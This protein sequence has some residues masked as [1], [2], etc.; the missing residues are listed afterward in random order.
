ME[1]FW[2]NLS[3]EF[4]TPFTNSVLIFSVI[5]FIILLVPLVFNRFKIPGIIGLILSG[6]LIGPH[7]LFLI[8]KN[9]AVNL[10][11]TIGL[12]YI[13]FIAGLELDLNDF[14]KNKNK[15]IVFGIFTFIIPIAIGLPVCLYVLQ[16]G[17]MTSLLISSM[18]A[19]HTLIA[20]PIV[21]RLGI[22]RNKAVA[23]AV[24]GTILTDTAVLIVLAVISGA[25]QGGVTYLLWTRLA[26]SILIFIAIVFVLIP[27]ISA[28]FFTRLEDEK[29]AHFI[30]VLSVVFFCAFL[31]EIAGLEPIIG[32]FAAG[33]TLNRLIPHHS[34]LMNRI[35]FVGNSLFIPFFLISV[36]M[37][38]DL[39][40]VTQGPQAIIIALTLTAVALLSKWIAAFFTGKVFGFSK[41]QTT[42]IFG[43]S[44]AHA[45]A[46]L[47]VILVGFNLKIIDSN[48]LNGTVVLILI[49]CVVASFTA[50]KAGKKVLLEMDTQPETPGY[51]QR[52]LVPISNPDTMG[53]LIDFA[54]MIKNQKDP[55]PIVGLSVVKDGEQA[56][57]K[58]VD[59]RKLLDKAIAHA[60]AADQK[61]EITCTIDRNVTSGIQR[62]VKEQSITEIVLGWSPDKTIADIIFGKTFD[63]LVRQTSQNIFITRFVGPLNVHQ[64][65][66]LVCP[67]FAEKEK[68]FFST[69]E[70]ALRAAASLRMGLKLYSTQPAHDAV[71][72]II[73]LVNATV[74]LEYKGSLDLAKIGML[75]PAVGEFDL[76]MIL[77][78]RAG[79]ISYSPLLDVIPKKMSKHF[80]GR[81]F[82]FVYP[83][84]TTS[85][86]IENY[87]QEV[88]GGLL[89]KG[90]SLVKNIFSTQK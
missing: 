87:E 40:V 50:E 38:I 57:Q 47:A 5:L 63:S 21:T 52:I 17:F 27:K 79:G 61:I 24:G 64:N 31:A 29:S 25:V 81:S 83:A 46:T 20:Y 35:E 7:G 36:G 22:A 90:I 88:T 14:Q 6:I 69:I 85:N 42:L 71:Q 66:I 28:W 45:A 41:P 1:Q 78:S 19:T 48:T 76:L 67:P 86:A 68:G 55:S 32:A 53:R 60:A 75:S 80:Q 70:N 8:Q 15:S 54:M 39:D 2:N 18:F 59:S 37:I 44:S 13:M 58:L 3:H 9:S 62:V 4:Q 56:E 33:L 72:R 26:I 51:S 84:T 73:V 10:F 74:T 16:F 82:V 77:S 65:L 23:V 34:S 89:E 43:L 12:L 49:T 11:S 30:F